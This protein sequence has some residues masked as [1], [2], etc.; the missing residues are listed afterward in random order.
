MLTARIV[1]TF[2]ESSPLSL[3]GHL[4]F[5]EVSMFDPGGAIT[6]LVTRHRKTKE[7]IVSA[8]DTSLRVRGLSA[9][10]NNHILKVL[11]SSE[12][13]L[14]QR[15]RHKVAHLLEHRQPTNIRLAYSINNDVRHPVSKPFEAGSIAR[16]LRNSEYKYFRPETTGGGSRTN[17]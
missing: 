16:H 2:H 14:K 13:S 3:P 17:A 11:R 6:R 8:T 12:E 15:I 9:W 4:V 10:L 5:H 7:R 1:L